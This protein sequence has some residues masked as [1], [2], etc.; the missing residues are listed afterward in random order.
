M[1]L[2]VSFKVVV[3]VSLLIFS[4]LNF[5]I[6]F[7]IF[8]L[9]QI[10]FLRRSL[11]GKLPF[12]L[13][14]KPWSR[15]ISYKYKENLW[16]DIYY[17]KTDS[18]QIIL[19]AHGGGWISGYR[20]QPNNISWYRYLVSKGFTVATIDYRYGYLN[21]I[22][23]LVED[24]SDAYKFVSEKFPKLKISLMG[25][26]AGGHLALYFVLKYKPK[27]ENVVAYYTPCDLLDIWKSPSLFAKFAVSTTLK[28]LPNKSKDLY[29]KYSPI[30]Y[31]DKNL[32]PIL[33]VHGLKD[34]VV[35]FISS[36]RMYKKLRKMGNKAKL[37]LHPKGDHGF[38]FVLKDDKTR[39]ILEKTIKFLRGD[40]YD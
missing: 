19:F 31:V 24:I 18:N 30:S 8:F 1:N 4:F 12:D 2:K 40:L 6:A 14:K 28:R 25:L 20:R 32:P 26:S 10:P 37:L 27:V 17:P 35:P 11:L 15:K 38:E 13:E 21:D 9:L 23:L 36:V 29:I 7:L 22:E 5:F 33:L 34:K 39:E 3:Y 16:L